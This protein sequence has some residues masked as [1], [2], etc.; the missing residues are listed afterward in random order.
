ML[1]YLSA[2]DFHDDSKAK[3]IRRSNFFERSYTNAL[4]V[5]TDSKIVSE[6]YAA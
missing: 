1:K 2:T 4:L 6:I 5:M 3:A